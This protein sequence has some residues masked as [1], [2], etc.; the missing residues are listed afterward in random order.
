MVVDQMRLTEFLQDDRGIV[1]TEYVVFV[2]GIGTLLVIGVAL[3][4]RALGQ[5]FTSWAAYFGG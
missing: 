4:F 2:A 1:S 3:L 5:F